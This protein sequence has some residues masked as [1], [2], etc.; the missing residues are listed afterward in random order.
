M[1]LLPCQSRDPSA[2]TGMASGCASVNHGGGDAVGVARITR[3]PFACSRSSVASSQ[4]NENRPSD[5]S[6]IAHENT[7]TVAVFTRACRMSASSS[8]QTAASHCSGL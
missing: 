8:A 2:R 7:P 6:S 4:S 5:G 3:T 1:S